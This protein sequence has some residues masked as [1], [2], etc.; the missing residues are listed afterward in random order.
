MNCGL[1]TDERTPEAL[2]V[3]ML[4]WELPATLGLLGDGA[5]KP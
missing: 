1:R 3:Q 2:A 5:A 4:A